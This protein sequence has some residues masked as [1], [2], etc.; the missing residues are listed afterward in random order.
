ML[1]VVYIYFIVVSCVVEPESVPLQVDGEKDPCSLGQDI[2][3]VFTGFSL[4]GKVT[5]GHGCR[6]LCYHLILEI[7]KFD[8][9]L[10]SG[11][12]YHMCLPTVI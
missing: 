4:N 3:F 8:I 1:L 7:L 2:N 6:S 11:F 5:M 10:L 12:P 9:S